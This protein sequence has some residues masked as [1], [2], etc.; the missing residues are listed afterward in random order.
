MK[1][2]Y[3]G[4]ILALLCIFSIFS[5][6][7]AVNVLRPDTAVRAASSGDWT[8]YLNNPGHSGFNSAETAI[9]VSTAG[10][11]KQLWSISE[12][13]ILSTQP[14]VANGLSYRGS[15]DGIEHATHLDGTQAWTANLG[16]GA[17][18]CPNPGGPTSEGVLSTATIASVTINGT[19]TT[20]DFV[21][22][23]S[24][25]LYALNAAT[26]AV[27][28]KTS[29]G[30]PPN[31]VLWASPTFYNGS[32]YVGV[33]S[34]DCPLIQ[35]K[36]FQL[37]ASTGAIQNTFNAAPN[38]CTGSGI[39][40]SAAIDT[41]NGTL[42]VATGNGNTCS[43]P[44]EYGQ[45]MLKLNASNLSY[46]SSWQIPQA[47][48]GGNTD[49]DFISS[50]TLFTT[51][52][53][54]T[55]HHL[56]GVANKDGYYYAFDEANIAGGP[57]WS[58]Q[59]AVN[60]ECPDCG[61]GSI[62][63]SAWDGTN[64][65]VAGGNTTINGQSCQGGLRALNPATGAVIWAQCMPDG[66]VL[67]AVSAVPGVVALTEG[68]ALWLMATSDGHSLF[69]AVDNS[70]NSFY[71]AA[72]TIS[73]GVVYAANSNGNFFAYGL[74]SGSTPTPP[75]T[76]TLPPVSG[77]VSKIWYFAE[78]RAGAGFDEFLTLGN[79]TSTNCQVIITYM[80]QPDRGSGYTKTVSIPV[81]AST[82]VTRWVDSDLGTSR[83][84]PGISVAAT[85]SVDTTTTPACTGIVAERPM[86]FNAHLQQVN[87]GSDVL[88]VTSP[89]TT[90]YFADLA[91]GNQPGGG[92]YSSYLPILN[93]GTTA[94]N[95]T[96]TYYAGGKQVGA[97]TLTVAANSRG[98]IFPSQAS[99]ALPA[100]VSVVLTSSAPIVSER[101]T[102]FHAIG[103]GN[104]GVVSG[105]ADVIGVQQLSNDWLFAEGYTGGRFQENF[106][107]ANLDTT[108][109]A[110]ATVT[111]ML[112]Y[113]TGT[114][115]TFTVT[116][117]PLSQVIWNVNA[118]S[119]GANTSLSVSAEITSTGAQI[120]VERE[121]FFGYNHQGDGRVTQSMGGTD[122]LGLVKSSMTN[123]YSFAEGYTN[124]GY[125]EWLTVQNPTVNPEMVNVTVSNG[126]GTV[127]T[128]AVNVAAHSRYTVDMVAIVQQHM[129]HAGNGYQGY[130]ISMA[131]QSSSGPFVVER[132]MYWNASGTQGGSDVIGY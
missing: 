27:I 107:I 62:S 93:P 13:S 43:L 132:P 126:V 125:D 88:G 113:D 39:I 28:W 100:R 25:F 51:T 9:N 79:P 38:G 102:Y 110:P 41:S 76:P 54:G 112:E 23:A 129:F 2:K 69:K 24:D 94:A 109:N 65:Y 72:P 111:I 82:R 96:A 17:T 60:G 95:V 20:V 75:P 12:G 61:S 11:L 3:A 63:P 30:A 128:F 44:G 26:G 6:M 48:L 114:T 71:Y 108:A 124:L 97:Q 46:V 10:S 77:P 127:Y 45:T 16:T 90:F 89:G 58:T 103:G 1:K 105:A 66:P 31:V 83:A 86:Y 5:A 91:T 67:G 53:G 19:P 120:A 55:A 98:T 33:A 56:V 18:N 119:T 106:V 70:K 42:Y 14:V 87:S 74:G 92:F 64:L 37:N 123:D 4:P 59:V 50:P 85:V 32:V 99:P 118:N 57:L 121:M 122:V 78:G 116:V 29:L 34:N 81:N 131:V 117:N 35:G 130:N 73:N 22:S 8:T 52:I 68:T 7:L 40:G 49:P 80:T 15:W 47:Q 21:G 36:E 104:A 115:K 101:P 84:G